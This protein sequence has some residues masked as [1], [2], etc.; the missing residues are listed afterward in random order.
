[1][2]TNAITALALFG[3]LASAL[4]AANLSARQNKP[5]FV[6]GNQQ[7]PAETSAVVD[8]IQGSVTC[9]ANA[10]TIDNIPDVTSGGQTFS[11]IN[12]ASSGQGPLAFSLGLFETATPLAESNLEAFQDALNVYHATEAGLR[13]E[14]SAQVNSIKVPKFFLQ[15]QIS[16]IETALGRAP[17]APGLQ[18]DHLRDKINEAA[19]RESQDLKDQVTQLATQLQ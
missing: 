1:M 13:S 5:C 14:G 17:T 11:Q 10:K 16:R 9:N 2:Y 15:M 4:P 18:V 7:L 6:I 3:S 8:Q 12:F 19:G